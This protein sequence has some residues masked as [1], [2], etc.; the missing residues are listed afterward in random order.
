MGIYG[1]KSP[2]F[3]VLLPLLYGSFGG[4]IGAFFVGGIGIQKRETPQET[5]QN[6][7]QICPIIGENKKNRGNMSPG[8]LIYNRML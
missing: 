3:R 8:F 4:N 6:G 2:F 1:N 5:P 7:G